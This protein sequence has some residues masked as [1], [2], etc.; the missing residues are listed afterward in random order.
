MNY[1]LQ[2]RVISEWIYFAETNGEIKIYYRKIT[3]KFLR[4]EMAKRFIS[5]E[6][7][8]NSRMKQNEL[9]ERECPARSNRGRE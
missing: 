6:F 1:S 3:A 4:N 2:N 8:Q 9:A 7:H 5:P